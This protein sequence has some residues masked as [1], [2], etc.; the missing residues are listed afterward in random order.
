MYNLLDK[1]KINEMLNSIP[2]GYDIEITIVKTLGDSLIFYNYEKYKVQL[3]DEYL[4]FHD[5]EKKYKIRYENI[6][7]FKWKPVFKEK[8]NG[9]TVDGEITEKQSKEK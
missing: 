7:Q 4:I 5:N 1:Y 9:I 2:Y 3:F 6:I 8:I